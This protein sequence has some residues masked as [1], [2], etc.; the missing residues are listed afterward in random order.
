MR[1]KGGVGHVTRGLWG[2]GGGGGRGYEVSAIFRFVQS[3][4]R[5]E[6]LQ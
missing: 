1:E 5:A 4:C 3:F 2:W 6:E